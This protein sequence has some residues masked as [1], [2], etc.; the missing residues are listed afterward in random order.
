MTTEQI[1]KERSK[2]IV[3]VLDTRSKSSVTRKRTDGKQDHLDTAI[4]FSIPITGREPRHDGGALLRTM[5]IPGAPTR[6]IDDYTDKDGKVVK[7]LKS[8]GYDKEIQ[9]RT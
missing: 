2:T 1:V 7:G 9:I 5:Y 4:T 8:L 6:F 3:F